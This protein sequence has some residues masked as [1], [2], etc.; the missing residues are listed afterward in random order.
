MTEIAGFGA[1]DD[2]EFARHLVQEIGVAAVPGSSFY[3]SAGGGGLQQ[4]RFAFCKQPSTI[5]HAVKNL[6][7]FSEDRLRRASRFESLSE[8]GA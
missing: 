7:N 8:I 2:R 5:D 4:I 1:S 6:G 3:H